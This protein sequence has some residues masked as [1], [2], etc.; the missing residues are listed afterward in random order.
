MYNPANPKKPSD[1]PQFVATV[2][3]ASST[4]LDF[5]T[6]YETYYEYLRLMFWNPDIDLPLAIKTDYEARN[7]G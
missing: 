4:L 6:Y 2:H 1:F 7:N 5:E 3:H